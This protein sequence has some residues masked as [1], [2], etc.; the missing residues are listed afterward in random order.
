MS[1]F[2]FSSE[3]WNWWVI[4]LTLGNI[5][6]CWWLIAWTSKKRAGE[7][8][9]GETTG[10]SWDE[11]LQEYNNPLPRWWLWLFHITLVFSLIYI[12]LYPGLGKFT[13]VWDWTQESQYDQEIKDAQ[14]RFDPIFA[15]Y[16]QRPIPEL[17]QDAQAVKAGQRLYLNYCAT[18][19]GSDAHGGPGFPNLSD[20]VWLYGGEPDTIKTSILDGRQGMMPAW[21]DALGDA[22]VDEVTAYVISISGREADP[23]KAEAGKA[24]FDMMCVACHAADGTG[25]PA[26]GAPNLTDADWLY[27][28][29]PGVIRH[30]IAKGR[31]GQMPSHREFLGEDKAH[32]L[33]AYLYS[34]SQ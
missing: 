10:H 30:S 4:G 3:F 19:H 29:S 25:N 5:L 9:V 17:A 8:A 7:S 1:D 16:A 24:R 26:L 11:S 13:G 18:C 28:G 14:E 12:V 2:E 34:L 33:A 22:G 31:N 27:G 15:A 21:Q 20:N 23:V 6:A 32:L